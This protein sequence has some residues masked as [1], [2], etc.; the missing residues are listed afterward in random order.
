MS[1]T[2]G[3]TLYFNDKSMDYVAFGRGKQP[4]VIGRWVADSQGYGSN[5]SFNLPRICQG[6]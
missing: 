1:S 2:K 5:A 4:L 3:K 6:L